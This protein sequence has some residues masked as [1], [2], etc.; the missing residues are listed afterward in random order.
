LEW[1]VVDG[2]VWVAIGSDWIQNG[3]V[4]HDDRL[5]LIVSWWWV[6]EGHQRV[7]AVVVDLAVV[8]GRGRSVQSRVGVQLMVVS[9]GARGN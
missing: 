4:G 2:N 8:V 5:V 3:R 1:R 6:G 7:H 9:M